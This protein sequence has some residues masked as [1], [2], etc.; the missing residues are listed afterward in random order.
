[1]ADYRS[2]AGFVLD[3]HLL[4][5]PLLELLRGEARQDV[6]RAAGRV[7]HDQGDRPARIVVGGGRREQREQARYDERAAFRRSHGF[8]PSCERG[9]GVILRGARGLR[10]RVAACHVAPP[11]AHVPQPTGIE[12]SGLALTRHF[13]GL[14]NKTC[15][16]EARLRMTPERRYFELGRLIAEMPD[17]GSG[18]ITPDVQRWLANVN[19]L[20]R[21]SGNLT[22][23]LQFAVACGHLG[24]AL[25]R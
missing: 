25:R 16:S 21:S 18:P 15:P 3:D 22:D 5:E 7:R 10:K 14:S 6:G 1:G 8:P 9:G 2:G 19:A 4:L 12:P 23:A 13:V 20:V 11:R 24:C 17:L